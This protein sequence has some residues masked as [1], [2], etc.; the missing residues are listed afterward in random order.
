M[1]GRITRGARGCLIAALAACGGSDLDQRQEQVAE[2]GSAVMPFD[3]NR[4][5]HVFEPLENGGLQT[6][7]SNDGDTE[8]V[9][10]IRA[11]LAEEAERLSRGD[12]HDPTM[13]HG[14]DMPGL[15]ALVT[16][17]DRLTITYRESEWGAEIEYVSEDPVLVECHPPV[18]RGPAA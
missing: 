13:I 6:V 17:H 8:Q 2:A 15:H 3:L 4:T 7:V 1:K 12:F 10:L 11:H 14:E 5:T 18:V 16:G 9:V